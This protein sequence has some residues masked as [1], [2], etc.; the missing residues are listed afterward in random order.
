MRQTDLEPRDLAT[1]S[2]T[3]Y[4]LR[5]SILS[6]LIKLP[7]LLK[8]KTMKMRRKERLRYRLK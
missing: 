3:L 2:M 1:P 4:T 8:N 6:K 5:T 7:G